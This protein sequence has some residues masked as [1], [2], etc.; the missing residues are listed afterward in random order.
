[1]FLNFARQY[2]DRNEVDTKWNALLEFEANIMKRLS[3]T[4]SIHG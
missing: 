3:R 1:M 4:E 2:G